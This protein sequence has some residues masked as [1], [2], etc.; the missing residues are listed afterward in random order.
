M[1]LDGVRLAGL[2]GAPE[3]REHGAVG[4]RRG[5]TLCFPRMVATRSKASSAAA[6]ASGSG[7]EA[8]TR[9]T[10][11]MVVSDWGA[12]ASSMWANKRRAT[13][14][15]GWSGKVGRCEQVEELVVLVRGEAAERRCGNGRD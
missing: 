9:A 12:P 3:R 5:A 6:A 2:P 8:T 15:A 1:G 14:V 10:E 7:S 13:A 11:V 4:G